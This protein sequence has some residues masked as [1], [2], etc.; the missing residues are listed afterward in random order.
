LGRSEAEPR[1]RARR[2]R[3]VRGIFKIK[4]ILTA[5]HELPRPG[6]ASVYMGGPGPI[7]NPPANVGA[8]PVAY[9]G[10]PIM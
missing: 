7:S 8:A 10:Q 9:M 4:S 6:S 1:R 2:A 3:P 5:V